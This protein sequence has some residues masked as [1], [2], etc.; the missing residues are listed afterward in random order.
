MKAPK[1][2]PVELTGVTTCP[3]QAAVARLDSQH[4]PHRLP[5][6]PP[7]LLLQEHCR[8]SGR[9]NQETFLHLSVEVS[10]GAGGLKVPIGRR[11]YEFSEELWDDFTVKL[12]IHQGC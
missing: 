10:P 8:R 3:E 12:S 7:L 9:K 5:P 1:E 4:C 11:G 2:Q 6:P